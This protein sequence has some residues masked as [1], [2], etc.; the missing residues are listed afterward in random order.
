M[1]DCVPNVCKLA[2]FKDEEVVLLSQSLQL[3]AEGRCVVLFVR[4]AL[5]ICP[6]HIRLVKQELV[7]HRPSG[8]LRGSSACRR[9]D[10]ESLPAAGA[11]RCSSRRPTRRGS[12]AS[13]AWS[14]AALTPEGER[15]Q[16]RGG[17]E[18]WRAFKCTTPLSM[19]PSPNTTTG[20]LRYQILHDQRRKVWVWSTSDDSLNQ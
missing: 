14:S 11:P 2:I 16:T 10:P 17:T 1:L 9:S 8:C 5:I 15:L 18:G 4:K 12:T 7:W 6:D 19:T 3:L 20:P 13:P